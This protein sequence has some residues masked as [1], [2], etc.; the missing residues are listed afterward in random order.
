[1]EKLT[2]AQI[3]V[4]NWGKNLLRNFAGMPGVNVKLVCELDEKIRTSVG[5]QYPGIETVAD[6][7]KVIND[8]DVDAI[9]I[10]TTPEA[11]F[12]LARRALEKGKHVFVEK[13]MVLNARDGEALVKLAKEKERIIMVGHILE[14][15]PGFL[16]MKELVDSGELGETFYLY[17]TR[18]NLGVVREHENALWSFAPHDISIALMLMQEEPIRVVSTGQSYLRDGIEDVVFTTIHFPNKKMAHLHVSWLDPHKIR[19][20][21][22][23]GSKKMAVLDD[24]ESSEKM[25][26]YDKGVDF[27]EGFVD[28]NQAISLR[29]GDINIP[30]IK[31]KEPLSLECQHFI[32]CITEGKEPVSNGEDG[33]RVSKVLEAAQKSLSL[34]GQPVDINSL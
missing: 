9:V 18:V 10:A 7:A 11:H 16:K 26:I 25:R 27:K 1:M 24:M 20:L 34:G 22:V 33:L 17:S 31:M 3:G 29:S 13:P 30:F 15:H 12:D 32:E 23:V 8:N 6:E 28:Y 14:Y 19:K 21:T 2:I 4:G 5:E